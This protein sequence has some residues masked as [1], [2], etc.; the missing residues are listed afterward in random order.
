[1]GTAKGL[2]LPTSITVK[3]CAT[4]I[5]PIRVVFRRKGRKNVGK[6]FFFFFLAETIPKKSP[7]WTDLTDA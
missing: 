6:N 3:F 7:A 4:A 1:M 5:S 2:R